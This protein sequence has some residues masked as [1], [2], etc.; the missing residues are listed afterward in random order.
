[1]AFNVPFQKEFAMTLSKRRETIGQCGCEECRK[2]AELCDCRTNLAN[3]S[4]DP[5]ISA[6]ATPTGSFEA[7]Y[8]GLFYDGATEILSA[9]PDFGMGL[10]WLPRDFAYYTVAEGGDLAFIWGPRKAYWFHQAGASYVPSFGAKVTLTLALGRF[11]LTESDGTQYIFD[12]S[13]GVL[14]QSASPGGQITA[15]TFEDNKVVAVTRTVGGSSEIREFTYYG[16]EGGVNIGRLKYVTLKRSVNPLALLRRLEFTYYDSNLGGGPIGALSTVTEQMLDGDE[17]AAIETR[18]F[19]YYK[20]G[21]APGVVDGLLKC[22]VKPEGYARLAKTINP[23]LASDEETLE[24]S[25]SWYS[26]ASDGSHRLS[27]IKLA[28]GTRTYLI[29]FSENTNSGYSDG[30]NTW[31]YKTIV[32]H[33]DGYLRR[34]YANHIGQEILNI[35]EHPTDSNVYWATYTERWEGITAK[36]P[37]VSKIVPPKGIDGKPSEN[38]SPTTTPPFLTIPLTASGAA[39]HTFEYFTAVGNAKDGYLSSESIQDGTGSSVMVR[40]Y[41]YSLHTV[42]T[43]STQLVLLS[44]RKEIPAI[45]T[46]TEDIE[47]TYTYTFYGTS[48][49]WLPQIKTRTTTLPVIPN[50]TGGQPDQNGNGQT[51]TRIDEYDIQGRLIKSTDEYAVVTQYEYDDVTGARLRMIEDQGSGRLN[52]VTDYAVDDLGRTIQVLGPVRSSDQG[53]NGQSVRSATW[54]VY[55]DVAHETWSAKGCATGT[56]S[57]PS[58]NSSLVNPVAITKTNH[59]GQTTDQIAAVRADADGPLSPG[60]SFPQSSWIRWTANSYD[61]AGQ[62]SSARVYHAIPDSGPGE[63]G[64]NYG[65]TTFG[66]DIMGRQNCVRSPGGTITRT[67]FDPRGLPTQTWIGTNDTGATD[68]DPDGP[69]PPSPTIADPNNMLQTI[70]NVYDGGFPSALFKPGNGVLTSLTRLLTTA[71]NDSTNRLTEY[72]YDYRDRLITESA[73]V[74]RSGSYS[75]AYRRVITAHWYDNLDRPTYTRTYDTVYT[76][77]AISPDTDT[78]AYL[79]GKTQVLT[80]KRGRVYRRKRWSVSIPS[81]VPY[82]DLNLN[83]PTYSYNGTVGDALEDNMWY[84]GAG[85]LLKRIAMGSQGYVKNSYDALGRVTNRYIGYTTGSDTGYLWTTVVGTNDKVFDQ[86]DLTY[87]AAGNACETIRLQ[88]DQGSTA[89]GVLSATSG[90]R[91]NVSANWLDGVD[92][93]IASANYGTSGARSSTPPD[94]SPSVLV[95]RTAYNDRGEAFQTIDPAGMATRR[96]WD[97]AGRPIETVQNYKATG[98]GT[99]ENVTTRTTYTLDGNVATLTAVNPSTGDQTTRY[100]YGTTLADSGIAR[101]DLL[102]GEVYPDAEDSA[103]RIRYEYNRQ[104]D[105]TLM[106]DQNGTE[107]HYLYDGFGRLWSDAVFFAAGSA[108]DSAVRRLRTSFEIRGMAAEM[109]SDATP[110]DMTLFNRVVQTF[111]GFGQIL[112]DSQQHFNSSGT[113]VDV[114]YTYS[115][116]GT[117]NASRRATMVYPY[118]TGTRQVGYSYSGTTDDDKLSRISSLSFATTNPIVAYTYFGAANVASVTYPEPTTDITLTLANGTDYSALDPFGRIVDLA[119]KQSTTDLARLQYGYDLAS[120]R[121]FRRDWMA[122]PVSGTPKPFDEIYTYDGMHRLKSA[123]RGVL[124]GAYTAVDS[125]S[126]G[127][128]WQLDQTGNWDRFTEFD[129]QGTTFTALDQTRT[130]NEANEIEQFAATTGAAWFQPVYDRN[131]NMTQMPQPAAPASGYQATYDAW[132]RLTKIELYGTTTKVGVYQYDALNRRTIKKTYTSGVFSKE[133]HYYYS[134]AWQVLEERESGMEGGNPVSITPDRQWVWGVRYV[135]DCALRDE[136]NTST[137]ALVE[138]LYAMQDG[139]WNVVAI[140]SA[141]GAVAERFVYEPYGEST[142][143]SG[144]YGVPAPKNWDVLFTGQRLSTETGI[145]LYRN[146]WYYI[147][148]GRFITRDPLRLLPSINTYQYARSIPMRYIDPDGLY[149]RAVLSATAKVMDSDLIWDDVEVQ[150]E[151]SIDVRCEKK[152]PVTSVGTTTMVESN[153][154]WPNSGEWYTRDHADCGEGNEPGLFVIWRAGATE[155]AMGLVGPGAA[156]GA[157]GGA[158]A[159]GIAGSGAPGVGTWG[160]ASIGGTVGGAAGGAAGAGIEWA[161]DD[162]ASW[163]FRMT[164]TVCCICRDK[165]R[166]LWEI[167]VTRPEVVADGQKERLDTNEEEFYEDYRF[168]NTYK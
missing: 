106:V 154:D 118:S 42:S 92:R 123:A 59:D 80:D 152:T 101:S 75:P 146:R 78:V 90:S 160:G 107:H 25:D 65:E 9:A 15:N 130:Q 49:P 39:V 70:E 155:G 81:T 33:P 164:W 10:N 140:A 136:I 36:A 37:Y 113:A 156:V 161:L 135:D 79:I 103:D 83:S 114:T 38:S 61:D 57:G 73:Y 93:P 124:N 31:K 112:S 4:P 20:T 72:S 6:L 24:H 137:G 35:K 30:Y 129:D 53:V 89:T 143:Y 58:Y 7:S 22:V 66:Y 159:G 77:S 47:T 151:A 162:V 43:S 126:F 18:M 13:T 95:S 131:G 138:R 41:D 11:T 29:L 14:L 100:A 68:S 69:T 88:R 120:N 16:A 142:E 28:G 82:A 99:D 52:L 127:Q 48:S 27:E 23:L 149:D 64:E 167:K 91:V 148:Q 17:W 150:L 102:I 116:M 12:E 2:A 96:A 71:V 158:I 87:D 21:E 46:S 109:A 122:H 56:N 19:R 44:S 128:T 97:D 153:W 134:N 121:T 133:R 54:T 34:F 94:S 40:E 119:W 63:P 141:A 32:T 26:Y 45:G 85:R 8:Y 144:T 98:S 168:E 74:I 145:Y 55:K 84:D 166:D 5:S 105:R 108:V 139:N 117:T 163:K 76:Y 110:S 60:D 50:G 3:A 67:V 86:T 147:T 132:N 104:G 157:A 115:A 111:N 165:K 1:M 51:Y 62:G 125:P